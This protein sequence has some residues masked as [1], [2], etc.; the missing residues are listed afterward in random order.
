MKIPELK[1]LL[2]AGEWND[3]E[4]K[5]A[6]SAVSKSAFET[7]SAFANTHG[8]WIVFGVSQHGEEFRTTGVEMPNKVQ[9]DFLSVLHAG[10]KVNHD[11]QITEKRYDIDGATVLAFHIAENLRTRKPVYLDGDIRRTFLRKGS[12]DYKAQMIDI[13]RML[14]DATADRWDGQPFDRVLLKEAFHPSSLRWYRDRF[15][16]VNTGFDPKQPDK[17]FLY[18]WGYLLRDGKRYIPIRGAIMLFGSPLAVHQLIPRPT[19]DFQFLGYATDE[20]MPET[21]WIDRI[22]CEENII[23]AWDQL[24]SKYKF[25]MPKPFKDIDPVTLGR[26][27]D[28]PGFRVFREA[29]VNLLIHQDYGDHSRKAV[30]KFFRDGIQLWNPGDVF[31]DDSRLLEPGEKEVRNPVI[32]TAMR[33]IAMCEQAGTGMRMMREAWQALGHPAP[34]Y[35]ND[36]SRKAFDLFIP[37]LDKEVDMASDLMKAMFGK[38]PTSSGGTETEQVEAHEEAQVKAQEAQVGAQVDLLKWQKDIL[39]SCSYA[40]KTG[41]ELMEIAGYGSRTGNFKKGLQRLLDHKLLELTISDK[42]NSR[43][44]KYRLTAKGRAIV[45]GPMSLVP[46]QRK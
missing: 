10:A 38:T 25:F 39:T 36:R 16:Q 29:A 31:G 35:K 11:V 22:V 3:I 8:G 43:L 4:F 18:H 23:Q 34:V 2:K 44:Q 20:R 45:E 13:E 40:E 15:H 17:E 28:P 12:G 46:G 7:V 6:R 1:K 33:R 5:E 32:A 42:P 26:R 19:L 21:R 30:I 37:E 27:D 41:R 9:G 14:R 24:V